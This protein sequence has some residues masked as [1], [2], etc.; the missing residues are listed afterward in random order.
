MNST[1]RASVPMRPSLGATD[2]RMVAHALAVAS[3]FGKLRA[4]VG[5]LSGMLILLQARLARY[6]DDLPD[7]GIIRERRDEAVEHIAHLN[8]P[9]GHAADRSRLQEA[10]GHLDAA[11]STI[12]D[13]RRARSDEHI[14]KASARLTTAYRLMQSICDHR[15][16]LTMVD[17]SQACCSCGKKLV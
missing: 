9:L 3:I 11:I 14:G 10:I 6:P 8:P 13:M 12:E 4:I 17:T 15:I 5:Q 2:E 1:G 7:I 16:G